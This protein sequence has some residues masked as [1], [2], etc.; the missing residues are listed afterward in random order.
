SDYYLIGY[1]NNRLA[2]MNGSTNTVT[3]QLEQL[4][5]NFVANAVDY[6]EFNNT[7]FVAYNHVNGQPWGS[8][9]QVF[10]IDTEGGFSGDPSTNT[11]PGLIW[12][13]EKGKYGASAAG[14]VVNGNATGDVAMVVSENGFYLYLYFM[15][16]NGYVVGVQFDC[17]D[18]Q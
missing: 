10:L 1:S 9:D 12:A 6:I 2:K 7:K 18:I 5:A 8:A 16:T 15:F 13:A 11:T 4:G 14:G 3:S 17:V